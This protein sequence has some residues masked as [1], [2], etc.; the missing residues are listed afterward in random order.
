MVI[1]RNN[2]TA[3][4]GNFDNGGGCAKVWELSV[5][6]APLCCE[7]ETAIKNSPLKVF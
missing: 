1:N 3:L 7:P 2:C 5:L 6:S 4:E